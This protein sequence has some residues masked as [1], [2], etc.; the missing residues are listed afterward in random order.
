[1][2]PDFN[3]DQSNIAEAVALMERTATWLRSNDLRDYDT[4]RRWAF[5]LERAAL[6]A[7]AAS[8]EEER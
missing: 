5:M 2:A 6:R 7:R 3:S 8:D 1:M 4:A